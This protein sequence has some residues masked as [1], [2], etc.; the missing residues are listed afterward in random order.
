MVIN[1]LLSGM[2]LQVTGE[3]LRIPFGK[4][5]VHLREDSGNHHPPS[6]ILVV[7]E[8]LLQNA[9]TIQIL[10]IIVICPDSF[11]RVWGASRV[12]KRR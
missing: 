6:R 2:I 10:G 1:H 5:G 11:R 3:P 12:F 8:V 4:I 7:R 9:G